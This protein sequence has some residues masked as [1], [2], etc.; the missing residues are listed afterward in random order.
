MVVPPSKSTT[1]QLLMR[2][3]CLKPI[4]RLIKIFPRRAKNEFLLSESIAF[5]ESMNQQMAETVIYGD[6]T[7]HPQRF[8]G[9]AARFN[10]M[11]A[12]NAVNIIDAEVLA[13]T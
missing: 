8:T 5:L 9:L 2:L 13:V 1:A 4:L 6:A 11:K 7:V 3:V 12:K 10:D